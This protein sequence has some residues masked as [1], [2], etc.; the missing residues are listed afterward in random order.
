MEG[1]DS[2]EAAVLIDFVKMLDIKSLNENEMLKSSIKEKKLWKD[3]DTNSQMIGYMLRI[4]KVNG[5]CS[6]TAKSAAIFT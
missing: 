4:L 6:L 1:H 5:V 3:N 2:F